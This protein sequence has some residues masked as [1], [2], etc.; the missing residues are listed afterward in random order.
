MRVKEEGVQ[1]MQ[2]SNPLQRFPPAVG[3]IV[4]ANSKKKQWYRVFLN[5][6]SARILTLTLR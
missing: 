4:L 1:S 5:N 3:A 2:M 6:L